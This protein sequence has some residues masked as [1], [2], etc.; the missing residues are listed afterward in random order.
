MESKIYYQRKGYVSN[1]ALNCL[2]KSPATFKKYIDGLLEEESKDYFRFGQLVHL[3]ILE[4]LEFENTVLVYDYTV[5]KSPQQKS[6]VEDVFNVYDEDNLDNILIGSYQAN[7]ATKESDEKVLEKA[8]ALYATLKTYANYLRLKDVKTIIS[9][10]EF[11]KI[12]DMEL[13]CR[14][15]EAAKHLLFDLPHPLAKENEDSY[16]EFEILWEYNGV[17]CKS[18]ID[19]VVVDHTN[20][21]IK[22]VDFKTTAKLFN[23]SESYNNFGYDRQ[24]AF[25]T[26]ALAYKLKLEDYT[27]EH[28]IVACDTITHEAKVFK[29]DSIQDATEKIEELLDR[30][31]WHID[32]NQYEHSMEYYTNDGYETL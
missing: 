6:F 13:S 21:I 29:I 31:K 8:K 27:F 14:N 4:P 28:Y 23:F 1:S 30:A 22:L 15:H 9:T 12:K 26:K 11:N 24:L 5:P 2:L 17:K 3:R 25:Y 10:N 7:Y 32:N 16:N 20:K 19:R 18:L